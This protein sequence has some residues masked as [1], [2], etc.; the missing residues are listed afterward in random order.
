LNNS[1]YN[2]WSTFQ[3]PSLLQASPT[4]SKH[5]PPP[6][7]SAFRQANEYPLS[8]V[9]FSPFF[10]Y[11]IQ[12]PVYLFPDYAHNLPNTFWYEATV[13]VARCIFTEKI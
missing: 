5:A 8:L 3:W 9:Y 11:L 12:T 7:K 2:S 4:R 6:A 1:V 13:A 10:A